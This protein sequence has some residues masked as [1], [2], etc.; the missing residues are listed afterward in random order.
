MKKSILIVSHQRSGTHLTIDLIRNNFPYNEPYVS[1][2]KL[3]EP[4]NCR[5]ENNIKSK[6]LCKP[7]IF[8]SHAD[9]NYKYYY[10]T[11]E[12][13][14]H[15]FTDLIN[16]SKVIYVYREPKDVLIS[17]YYHYKSIFPEENLGSIDDFVFQDSKYQLENNSKRLNRVEYLV[18]HLYEWS[19]FWNSKIVFYLS[20]ESIIRDYKKSVMDIADFIETD[21]LIQ[22]VDV[23]SSVANPPNPISR[24]MKEG[25][26]TYTSVNFRKG[27]IGEY[28]NCMKSSTIEIIDSFTQILRK[29]SKLYI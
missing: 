28:Q 19:N 17:L 26:T 13:A 2:N 29:Q 8:K 3:L 5:L 24:Q 6:L 18:H 20:Y 16:N 14:Q 22:L 1:F 25:E 7:L 21:N 11:S 27:I 9:I 4:R 10:R 15:L 12:F 23:R